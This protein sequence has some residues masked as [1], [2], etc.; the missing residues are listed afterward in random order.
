M[1]EPRGG[2]RVVE[3]HRSGSWYGALWPS[4]MAIVSAKM[5]PKTGYPQGFSCRYTTEPVEL[6]ARALGCSY[7]KVLEYLPAERRLIVH[8]GIGWP[9]GTVD[10]V[11]LGADIGSPVAFAYQTGQSGM[12]NHLEQVIRLPNAE[13]SRRTWDQARDKRA[14]PAGWRGRH[15]SRSRTSP[16]RLS[17]RSVSLPAR[18]EEQPR[19]PRGRLL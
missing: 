3:C 10:H 11:T 8:A 4:C 6:S 15:L 2:R 9:A 1:G 13:T 19:A 5:L 16:S 12:S 7:A 17:T 14:Y 18:R